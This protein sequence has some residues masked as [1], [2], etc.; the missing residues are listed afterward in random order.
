[1]CTTHRRVTSSRGAAATATTAVAAAGALALGLVT[2]PDASPSQASPASA[3]TPA[4]AAV[5][6]PEG[7]ATENGGTTGGEGGETVSVSSG[8]AFLDALDGEGPRVIE[9]SGSIAID[10]MNDVPSDTTVLGRDGAEITGGGLDLNGVSNVI[11]QNIAFSGWDDDAINVQEGS[12]NIWIDHNSFTDGDDGAVDIKRES[13]YV[14]VSWNHFFEHGKTAL[15]GHSD[16]HT[17]DQGHLR[18]SYH[19]NFFDGTDSRHPRVRFGNPVHVYNNYYVG[20]AE[21]GVASTMGAGVLVE[22]NY[23]E[24][25]E[26][27]THTGYA[28]SDIGAIEERDNVY[29]GSGEPE[30][31]GGTVEEVPYSYTL[32]PAEDIASIVSGGAGPGNI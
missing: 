30:T 17:Q 7:W 20:N 24:D 12:T 2:V 15:L 3:Q 18:V 10:G 14:T 13:D 27:P 9:V 11:V 25:V 5:G 28:S 29:D 32:D 31:G 8:D 16:G 23:F 19:H 6:S 21:Y 26:H 22:G 1:M 4:A